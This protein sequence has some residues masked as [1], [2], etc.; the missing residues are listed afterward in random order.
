MSSSN[1]K[2]SQSEVDRLLSDYRK[3]MKEYLLEHGEI[4]EATDGGDF[5]DKLLIIKA[6]L[7]EDLPSQ[8]NEKT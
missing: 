4:I 8:L 5:G 3:E 7:I 6:S 2:Y 1:K